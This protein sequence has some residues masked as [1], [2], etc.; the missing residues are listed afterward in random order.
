MKI[1]SIFSVLICLA[2]LVSNGQTPDCGPMQIFEGSTA[3]ATVN[4]MLRDDSTYRIRVTQISCSLCDRNELR[5][6]I[7][8]KGNWSLLGDTIRLVPTDTIAKRD[9]LRF[10]KNKLKPLFSVDRVTY[11][12]KNDSLRIRILTN[13]IASDLFTFD[14]L[15]ETHSNGIVK[16][17][18]YRRTNNKQFEISVSE[19]GHIET[20]KKIKGKRVKELK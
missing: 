6:N 17:L 16:T 8:Q 10:D 4:L 20:I 1:K 13:M 18:I 9:F 12:I 15:Y 5:N 19:S 2:P 7:D 11:Q 14:L 3:G